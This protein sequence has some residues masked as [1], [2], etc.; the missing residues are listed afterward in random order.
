MVLVFG[1][2]AI[3]K[4]GVAMRFV[5]EA[6]GFNRVVRNRLDLAPTV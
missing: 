5:N 3:A 6:K 1:F 2:G 4:G